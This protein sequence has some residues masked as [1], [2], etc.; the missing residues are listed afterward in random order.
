M[1]QSIVWML[2]KFEVVFMDVKPIKDYRA[3][4]YPDKDEALKNPDLL[5]TLPQ[6]WRG[7]AY[8]AAALS[9]L[10]LMILTSCSQK[11]GA[12]I[13]GIT[14][15]GQAA[16]L[17]VH[18]DGRGSFGCESVA[19]PAFLSEEEAFT[20]IAEEAQR[21]G[22]ILKRE[23]P[24]L[25]NVSVP[26]TDLSYNPDKETK[27]KS[28]KG[29][30]GLDGFDGSKQIAFEF[31]SKDDLYAWA[32]NN[33]FMSSVETFKFIEAAEVLSDGIKDKTAGMTVATF[34]D[35]HYKF[36]DENVQDIIKGT[37]DDYKAMEEK[38]RELVKADL[39]AQVRDFLSWLKGQGII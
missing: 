3:P 17:F 28:Q 7:S 29:E 27:T 18:G 2:N 15:T 36:D 11:R 8:T 5:K 24:A 22:I 12:R 37:R 35:P 10:V 13:A 38:L 9:A 34:Y 33:G 19:P 20:V 31:V 26:L 39:R 16:P 1:R 21:E 25:K 23:A 14:R 4:R 6:R 32:G 30:L